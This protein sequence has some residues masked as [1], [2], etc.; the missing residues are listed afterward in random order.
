MRHVLALV[1]PLRADGTRV[2]VRATSADLPHFT[3][4]GGFDW[5]PAISGGVRVSQRVFGGDFS[6]RGASA[7]SANLSLAMQV[8]KETYPDAL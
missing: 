4:L 7:S 6:E 1:Q 8:I 2:D 5:E 3:G